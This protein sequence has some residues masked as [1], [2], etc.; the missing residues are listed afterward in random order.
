MTNTIANKALK[1]PAPTKTGVREARARARRRYLS[2]I[3]MRMIQKRGFDAISV[4]EV[5]ERAS[6]SIG[7][8]YR[9][10]STKNDLL[11]MVCD[12]INLDLL[13][14]LK[15][16]AAGQKGVTAKLSAAMSAYWKRH[17]DSS[18]AVLVAYREYQSLSDE[19]KERYLSAERAHASFFA[20]LIRAGVILEEFRNVDA[21]LV[22]NEIVFLAHMPALKGYVFRAYEPEAI[23]KEYLQ[24]ILLRLGVAPTT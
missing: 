10:I 21:H 5:A 6:M 19:T 12:E 14:E 15:D 9:H 22:A 24:M 3:V 7:G 8:L 13:E 1:G 17:W 2:Q 18:S 4:N 11:E 16:S 20:D 23:I